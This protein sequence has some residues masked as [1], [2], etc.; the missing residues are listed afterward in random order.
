[1]RFLAAFERVLFASRWIQAPLYVGLALSLALLLAR[2]AASAFELVLHGLEGSEDHLIVAVLGLVDIT[3]VANLVLMVV[4]AGYETFVSSLHDASS[5]QRLGW[6]GRIGFTDLKLKLMGS[7]VAISAIHLLEDFMNVHDVPD[8]DLGWR[9][10]LHGLFVVS[11]LFL[12]GMDRV[13][14]RPEEH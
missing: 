14:H 9:A 1:M 11:G 8:R 3:L 6:M 10:G 13:G 7:I 12:A 4:F 5:A 2:F